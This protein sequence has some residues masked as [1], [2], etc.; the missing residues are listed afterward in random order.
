ME[1]IFKLPYNWISLE[2]WWLP[3]AATLAAFT[4]NIIKYDLL[5]F[6]MASSGCCWLMSSED[7]APWVIAPLEASIDAVDESGL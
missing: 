1:C 7:T 2:P 3:G 4:Q 5:A 6:C